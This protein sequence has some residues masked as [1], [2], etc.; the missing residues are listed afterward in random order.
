MF[1][2]QANLCSALISSE[3]RTNR[4]SEMSDLPELTIDGETFN[5]FFHEHIMSAN[6]EDIM[7]LRFGLYPNSDSTFL[8]ERN[9]SKVKIEWQN[10]RGEA[11]LVKTQN[12]RYTY[13]LRF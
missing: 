2:K 3:A 4:E 11:I 5:C 9:Q 1:P 7:G 10:H 8:D 6:E 13:E 12:P